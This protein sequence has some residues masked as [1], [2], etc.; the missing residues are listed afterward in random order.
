M[1]KILLAVSLLFSNA[2]ALDYDADPF[3]L[4]QMGQWPVQN[5]LSAI[6]RQTVLQGVRKGL[7]IGLLNVAWQTASGV[8]KKPPPI[9]RKA[10]IGPTIVRY[11]QTCLMCTFCSAVIGILT[12]CK[13]E[14]ECQHVPLP[15]INEIKISRIVVKSFI[16]GSITGLCEISFKILQCGMSECGFGIKSSS[17]IAGIT[18]ACVGLPPF[19][20]LNWNIW[21]RWFKKL[22]I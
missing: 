12:Y 9:V 22:A 6:N 19:V 17:I 16:V 11:W 4:M 13:K 18:V 5:A 3:D 15:L 1:K 14:M 8:G 10:E 2:F 20:Y 21:K 7:K